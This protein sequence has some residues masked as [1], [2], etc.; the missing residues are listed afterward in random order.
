MIWRGSLFLKYA[1]PLVVLVSGALVVS[2]L[3]Q[4]YFS[5]QEN[6]LALSRVQQEKAAAAS[7]RI[8]RFVRELEHDL[9]WIAQ[10][11]WGARGVPLD[12]RRLD[13]LRLL[14]QVPAITEVSHID[15]GGHEQ[16]RVSRLAMDVIGSNADLSHDPKFVE[17]AAHK[18][19]FSPVYFRKESE[20]Y[21]TIAMAGAGEDAGVVA[22]EANLKFIWDVVSNLKVGKGGNAYVVDERGRLIA[23]P[24]ISLVLQ[25]TDLSALPQVRAAIASSRKDD[26]P[27]GA[28]IGRDVRGKEVL[29]AQASITPLNWSVFVELPVAEAFA[30][31]YASIWRTVLLVLIGVAISIVASLFLV[32]RMVLPI[33][34][35][36]SGAA[37]IGAGAL[38]HRID[39]KSGDELQALADEFNRM[40]E[41]LQESYTGLERKVDERTRDLTEALEQQTATSEILRV[42]S[43]SPT[44]VQPV[45]DA[46][47]ES[48]ARLCNASDALIYRVQ[49]DHLKAVA[50]FGSLVE[51]VLGE[52]LPIRRDLLAGRAII[53]GKP[54]HIPDILA[55][56]DSEFGYSK[57][58]AASRGYRTAL[59]VPM[60]WE[61]N[62][63]GTISIRRA[64]VDPFSDKQIALLKTFA[65]QAVIAIENVRLFKELEE[66]NK[67]LTESLEQQTATSEILRVISSSPTDIQPVLDAVAENA[68]RLC[69]G[70]SV[71]ILRI[72]D[73]GL[74]LASAWGPL[75]GLRPEETIP[76]RREFINGRA[77]IDKRV[78]HIPD[79]RRESEEEFGSAKAYAARLGFQA[80]LAAPMFREGQPIGVILVE[81]IEARAFSDKQIELLKTF[82]DQAVIAIEN[83][84]LFKE[85]EERLEQQTATSEILRVISSSPTDLR[86]V[87]DAVAKNA[88]VLC[89]ANDANILRV[90]GDWL[91]MVSYYGELPTLPLGEG[92]PIRRTLLTGRAIIDRRTI[93]IPDATA[94]EV[95]REFPDNQQYQ[96]RLGY[97]TI[98]VT[99][100]L[101]EDSGIGVIVIRRMEV[102]PFTD[103]QIEIVRTFADQA[104]IAI[105]NVRLF[106]EL[107]ERNKS[108]TESLEQQTATSEILRVISQSRTD[109]QPVFE[110]IA[111]N[112]RT[113]CQA[114]YAGVYPFDGELIHF[115][116]V[117]GFTAEAM[118]SARKVYPVSANREGGSVG[119]AVLTRRVAYIRDVREDPEYRLGSLA[120][121][122]GFRCALAVPM[123]RD[124]MPIGVVVVTGAEPAMFSERQ[125]AMLQ[126]FADQAVIGVENTRLFK[127]LEE[128]NKALTEALEQQT[129]TSEILR[130]I[131]S[132]PTNLQPV[133][134][135]IV[136]SAARLCD[137][138]D[139]SLFRIEGDFVRIVAEHG[140][141]SVPDTQ[142]LPI[143]RDFLT[144]RAILDR[145]IVQVTDLLD[146]AN[147]EFPGS[148]AIATR[149]GYRTMLAAPLMREGTAIG[150]I[151]VRRTETQPFT[152]KQIELLKTFADQAVIAIEN[153]RLF[154]QLQ[155]QL[156]QQTATSEILRVISQSQRDVQ[157]VF[158]AIA[159]NARKLC[160]ASWAAFYTFDDEMLHFATG[161]SM[162]PQTSD[163]TRQMFPMTPTRGSAIGR[164][165]LTRAVAYIPDVRED[166]EYRLDGL[167]E[168]AGYRSTVS[169]PVLRNERP[170]GAISVSGIEPEMFSERQ[171]TMLG[172]FADQAL[173]AIE[174]VRLFR[175]LE[176]RTQ[177]LARS[178]GQLQAL[179]DVSQTVN[180]TLDLDRV[181]SAIVT[182]AVQL[183]STD[184]GAVYEHD[185]A[186]GE[187]HLRATYGIAPD[188]VDALLSKSLRIGEGA[189]G[190]AAQQRATVEIPD[191][192]NTDAYSGPLR[193]VI[194][195]AEVR[196]V[197]AVPLLRE[198]RVLGSLTV[199]RKVAG[200]FPPGVIEILQTFAAQSA[201]AIQN[202]R[203]F[204]EIE[205]KSREL[206]VASQH[207]SQFLA[208][209][210]HELRTP[211]NAILGYTELIVDQIYGKVP[212]KIL[213]VLDRVQKSGRHLLGL[214]ND[215]LDL[216]KIEAG[217]LVLSVSE[218]SFQ[219]AVQSVVTSVESLAREKGL[220]LTVKVVPSLPVGRGDERRIVQVLLNLVGNAIKFTESGEVAIRV[221]AND[222][223]FL[224]SV[225]DTG[226]GIPQDQQARIFEEFQQVDDSSTRSKGGTGLGLAIARRIIEMH[227]GRLSV[228]STVGKGSTFSF[229]LP[230]RVMT[231]EVTA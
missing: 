201:I 43:S 179:A 182:R 29:A 97:R 150:A 205:Q 13:S 22:A 32:R 64:A 3:V 151:T 26:T 207:K 66:R 146:Q 113:L 85:L 230:V 170:I 159:R 133:L 153:V 94:E 21:M 134:E 227:G 101:R 28:M 91:K 42:I 4:I 89:D 117:V 202:A 98:L 88:A 102:R 16:L 10:T 96:R 37:R 105:E 119:R 169:V 118:D 2:G 6:K 99:P 173:I 210:S 190:R 36:R 35:L 144:G 187:F 78:I 160:E 58:L 161:D 228:E 33:Q 123:L 200:S 189:T 145:G 95:N 120:T 203:L 68:A 185:E 184:T 131:S 130:V 220:K 219:D 126:T 52:L 213:E 109:V 14:R 115:G 5:Y 136:R 46:V 172:T 129:A 73:G 157:P 143:R 194:E 166:A 108:L 67:A 176:S 83:V 41:R 27:V 209:M 199:S 103:K 147:A 191:I 110:A 50:Q 1:L 24:D 17:A 217:Q 186:S 31:L 124:G 86:P 18:T 104:V 51:S 181:L 195:R 20:P 137:A 75:P 198:D 60:L 38:D 141:P 174:N 111:V 61:G 48:A 79:Y 47:A 122:A 65:D 221:S 107:E 70:D 225:S 152:D 177:E 229:S 231:T 132:S 53:D 192:K 121:T 19:Y 158:E 9:S 188:L 127:E 175:E 30:P 193:Q 8:E 211:L 84:R 90:E 7:I 155:E 154:T 25:K 215:V 34:A 223:S 180:S 197:L 82:A 69:D 165:I 135:T 12:Q 49:G 112:A 196:S 142:P 208:N 59:V 114:T 93:H 39:V 148:M 40:T 139:A 162:T 55:E 106:K 72:A 156:E 214:I 171:I 168:T 15:P 216:S 224:V 218:Y 138:R 45:L 11:P 44:D 71:G 116:T 56:S 164:A 163:A 23:H 149:Y 178:V 204:R 212:E 57:T 183:S 206:E 62:A 167:A 140:L 87:L 100:L 74:K 226:P 222:E 77:I 63:I 54:I 81:R 92:L 125:I 128:R 80:A 76:I